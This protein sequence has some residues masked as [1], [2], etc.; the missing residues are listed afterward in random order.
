MQHAL[1]AQVAALEATLTDREREELHEAQATP[2]LQF[3]NE[4]ELGDEVEVAKDLARA[5]GDAADL[6]SDER[7]V[8]QYRGGSWNEWDD[9]RLRQVAMY[10]SG[11]MIVGGQNVKP[12]KL[13][14]KSVKG[15]VSLT[16]TYLYQQRFFADAPVGA[17]FKNYFARLDGNTVVIE[18]ITR[19]HRVRRSHVPDFD[20]PEN[21]VLGPL[22]YGAAPRP[23]AFDLLL[24]QTWDGCHDR[25]ERIAFTWEWLGVSVIGRATMYKAS[26]LLVGPQDT[27]KSAIL[28]AIASVFPVGSHRSVSLHEMAGEYHR[29]HMAGGRINF[30]NELPSKELLESTFAKAILSGQQVLCRHPGGVP[31]EWVS[32][33]AN[34]FA[35][36]DLPPSNDRAL[37]GRLVVLDCPNVVPREKQ[38]RN[39][40]DKIAREAPLI[41][42]HALRAVPAVLARGYLQRPSS[43]DE[44]A[45]EW[46]MNGDAVAVWAQET[47]RPSPTE[48]VQAQELYKD[49]RQ[50]LDANGHRTITATTLGIRLK[51]LGFEKYEN[52]GMRWR[53]ERIG[54]A[55]AS[56]D[57]SWNRGDYGRFGE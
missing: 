53:V 9:E 2:A 41:A 3:A 11:T 32:R 26:P 40:A 5:L 51:K 19:D 13:T 48:S 56:A 30:V 45:A 52:H 44:Q 7:K 10:Y 14:E 22:M 55:R 21:D 57:R 20:L 29:A 23:T 16:K 25:D 6:V 27:G 31:F 49:F 37:M 8:W 38:D 24:E 28:D 43:A 47:I 42:L 1:D 35:C 46:R 15:I 50:W 54:G 39:L 33:C 12:L 4:L 18:P 34:I 17:P 36:N